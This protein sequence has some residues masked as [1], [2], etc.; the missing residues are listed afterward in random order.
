MN[1][2]F[3]SH[4]NVSIRLIYAEAQ[5]SLRMMG[6]F[7]CFL[8]SVDF[9]FKKYNIFKKIFQEHFQN[10]T[11]FDP[12]QDRCPD[13][14]PYCLH[15]LSTDDKSCPSWKEL[16]LTRNKSRLLFSSAEMFKKPLGQTVWTQIRVCFGSTLFASMLN[17][18]VML[19]NY[20]QQTTSADNCFRCIFFLA[21]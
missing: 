2:V 4:F 11:W 14:G 18:S 19:G 6:T 15:S 16:S 20:L 21:L 1:I 5:F 3:D 17:S 7:A 13:L 8:S 9:Y 10:I 12:D